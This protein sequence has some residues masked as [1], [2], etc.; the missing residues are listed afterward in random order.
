MTDCGAPDVKSNTSVLYNSTRMRAGAVY[1]CDTGFTQTGK[2]VSFCGPDEQWTKPD[3][4]CKSKFY[5]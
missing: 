3:I 4:T 5:I 1:K 2:G